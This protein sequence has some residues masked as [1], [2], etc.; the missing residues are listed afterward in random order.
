MINVGFGFLAGLPS[1]YYRGWID[2][3]L[4]RTADVL[5]AFPGLLLT[6]MGLAFSFLGDGLR[7]AFD[8][9]D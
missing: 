7:E 5:F 9:R 1:G 4:S 8:V 3:L 2:A 6:I